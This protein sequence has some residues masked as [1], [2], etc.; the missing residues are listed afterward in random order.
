MLLIR[1]LILC[2]LFL[3]LF[4]PLSLCS[5]T[6]K[7]P[8]FYLSLSSANDIRGQVSNSMRGVDV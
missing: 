3:R 7:I 5:K 8:T 6:R 1:R 4:L 2:I